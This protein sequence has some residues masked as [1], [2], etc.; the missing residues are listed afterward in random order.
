M[1]TVTL[2]RFNELSYKVQ[3]HIIELMIEKGEFP[4]DKHIP[5]KDY[6]LFYDVRRY[7]P[8]REYTADGTIFEE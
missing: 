8:E 1:R 4:E 5:E 6:R 2:Y 3:N 7:F